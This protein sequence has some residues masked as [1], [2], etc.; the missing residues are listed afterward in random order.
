MVILP[1]QILTLLFLAVSPW[2]QKKIKPILWQES[3]VVER[4]SDGDSFHFRK[5]R[6]GE[7]VKVRLFGVDSPESDQMGGRDATNFARNIL[8]GEACLEALEKDRFARVVA[9][10]WIGKCP[11]EKDEL[12]QQTRFNTTLVL[13]GHAWWYARYAPVDSVLARAESQARYHKRGIW[14]KV[15]PLP[16]WEFRALK[17]NSSQKSKSQSR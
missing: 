1:I 11:R 16:P 2:A 6:T 8:R 12:S 17:R 14:S 7:K 5:T 15:N 10:V 3:G 4:V 13:Q 9:N